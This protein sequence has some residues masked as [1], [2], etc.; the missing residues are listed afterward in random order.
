MN[1][2]QPTAKRK[3]NAFQNLMSIHWLMAF[4]FLVIFT[5]G[6]SMV[7]LPEEVE[8]RE[9]AYTTHKSFGVLV[10]GLLITRIF[11]L[12]R[13]VQKKYSRRFPKMTPAWAKVFFLHSVLYIFMLALPLS[14]FFLSNS[15]KSDNVP[16]F[17]ITTP[18]LFPVNP[19]V[20]ELAR[21]LH[22][23]LSY[24]FASVIGLHLW[25]Q[26]KVVRAY[27]RRI[28]SLLPASGR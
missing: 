27:W 10:F 7:R 11:L 15:Y 18:D 26:Q 22:F 17:W 6:I 24:T 20:V 23:W 19:A 8:I 5:V 2:T 13:V 28:L 21:S 14:G 16:L 12:I 1:K 25:Q 4:C 3:A 9:F